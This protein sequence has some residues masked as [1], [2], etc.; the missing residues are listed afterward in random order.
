MI[1]LFETP[2]IYVACLA[3]YNNGILHGCW[4]DA[5]PDPE[6]MR[7][8]VQAMLADSPIHH[9]EEFAIHDTQGFG[10]GLVNEYDSL[11]R[12]AE[13]AGFLQEHGLVGLLV[14]SHVSGNL[15]E[16][17]E[18]MERYAGTHA[19]AAEYAR[20]LTEETSEIPAHLENYI[21]YESIARD[22]ELSGDIDVIEV[23]YE[24]VHIFW[25]H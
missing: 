19:S 6:V 7:E 3:A 8:E 18:M 22:M 21:D 1:A 16:A 13:L 20:E 11:E 9:A 4:I 14:L 17:R 2:R 24:E 5:D 25:S 23:G 12:I 10:H 15:E